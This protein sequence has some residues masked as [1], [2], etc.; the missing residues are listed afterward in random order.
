MTSVVLLCQ[1]DPVPPDMA[2]FGS[3][4]RGGRMPDEGPKLTLLQQREIEAR[5]LGP[6]IRAVQAE[7]GE[8]KTLD[9]LRRVIVELARQSGAALAR[10][11]GEATLTAFACSRERLDRRGSPGA[12]PAG[13]VAR[14]VLLQRHAL[15]LRRDV[16]RPGPGRPRLQPL[17]RP[18][19]RADRGLQPRDPLDA[20]TDDHGRSLALRL[21][22][23][24]ARRGPASRGG[25]GVPDPQ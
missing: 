11:V 1:I 16:S 10:Q 22:L 17:L 3:K 14:A 23:R 12:R 9:L 5:V 6:L 8:E 15:S 2:Y 25:A 18:R 21:P 24:R 20:H 13:A 4:K 7:L 19:L